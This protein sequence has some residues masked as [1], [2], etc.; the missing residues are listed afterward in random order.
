[1]TIYEDKDSINPTD[2]S[3]IINDVIQKYPSKKYCLNLWSHATG[4]LPPNTM[5]RYFGE[6][7]NV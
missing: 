4:W 2:M 5:L 3:Y 7:D 1:M 6:S